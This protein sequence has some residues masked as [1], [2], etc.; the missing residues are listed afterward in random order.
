MLFIKSCSSCKKIIFNENHYSIGSKKY[1]TECTGEGI[2][3]LEDRF[4]KFNN[5]AEDPYEWWLSDT[6][7]N[8]NGDIVLKFQRRSSLLSPICDFSVLRYVRR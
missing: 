3:E 8:S 1:C 7:K 4:L 2:R 6:T 5:K